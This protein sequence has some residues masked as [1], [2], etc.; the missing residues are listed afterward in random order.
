MSNDPYNDYLMLL[1]D[2]PD[3]NLTMESSWEDPADIDGD[4]FI[5]RS[6]SPID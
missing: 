6:S 2:D 5:S 3:K 4:D 1:A